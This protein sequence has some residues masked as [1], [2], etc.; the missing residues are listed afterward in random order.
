MSNEQSG[1]LADT[2][3]PWIGVH[4]LSEFAFCPRAGVC[5]HDQAGGDDGEEFCDR[6]GFYH[7]PIFFRTELELQLSELQASLNTSMLFSLCLV[8]ASTIAGFMLHSIFY[9]AAMVTGVSALLA[10]MTIKLRMARVKG[11]LEQWT[12]INSELPNADISEPTAVYWPNF[13]VAKYDCDPPKD[14]MENRDWRLRGKPWRILS[15]GKVVIPVFLRNVMEGADANS[16]NA[17]TPSLYNQ[18]FVRIAAYCHLLESSTGLRVP[19]GVILTRGELTGVAIPNTRETHDR[20]EFML[21]EARRTMRGLA[22]Q[23][24]MYPSKD[25]AKCV[26]CPHGRP[27]TLQVRFPCRKGG[28]NAKPGELGVHTASARPKDRKSHQMPR[29]FHSHCGDRFVWLPPHQLTIAT[30]LEET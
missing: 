29:R 8:I 25:E 24:N 19:Y 22:D 7:L 20:L 14:V 4:T 18:H 6:P 3:E 30:E 17:D 15:R 10:L 2:K 28:E 9:V 27:V 23:P 21:E 5:S 11:V 26:G 13:F 1:L 12:Q 16:R